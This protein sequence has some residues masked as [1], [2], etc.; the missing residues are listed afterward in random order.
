MRTCHRPEL[1]ATVVN[2]PAIVDDHTA[3]LWNRS[4]QDLAVLAWRDLYW[5]VEAH[6]ERRF[7]RVQ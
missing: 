1:R 5:R 4:P 6:I 2:P 3:M 7:A